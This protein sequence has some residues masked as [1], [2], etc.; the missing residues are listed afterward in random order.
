MKVSLSNMSRHEELAMR[1][2]L[3]PYPLGLSRDSEAADI[4]LCR[5]STG[6]VFGTTRNDGR[7]VLRSTMLSACADV[8]ERTFDPDVATLYR[9]STALPI[10]YRIAP[11]WLRARLLVRAK[12]DAGTG[13]SATVMVAE[14]HSTLERAREMLVQSLQSGGLD[15]RESRQPSITITHDVDTEKGFEKAAAM[16]AVEEELG[17][18]SIWFIPSDEYDFNKE[19]VR[20]LSQNST[21]GSHDT[22]HDGKLIHI[23]DRKRLVR[24]LRTSKE[25]LEGVFG[26]EVR[27]FRSP[28]L[29]FSGTILEGLQEAGYSFDFSLPSWEPSHPSVMTGF[30]VE[31]Y[32]PFHVGGIAEVPLSL[33]QDHQALYVLGLSTRQTAS[34]WL[35][36]A[37]FVL[38]FGGD[39]VLLVH[40]DYAFSEE[41]QEYKD[42]LTSLK[43]IA[44]EGVSSGVP[45]R[46]A[47]LRNW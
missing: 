32:H 3:S 10:S 37:R 2:L 24:R 43:L 27:C 22:K 39:A 9:L 16:K 23:K 17:M 36:Q 13:E 28:L 45:S 40:P 6:D 47:P 19:T 5:R 42:F 7:V 33:L 12:G 4:E 31:Y 15:L 30:G 21:I 41:L 25:R 26:G 1:I 29:Q 20:Y 18:Q 34:L 35:R 8:V 11:A 14:A 38:S 46:V 44:P